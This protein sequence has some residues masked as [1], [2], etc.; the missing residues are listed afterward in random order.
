MD[1]SPGS[2]EGMAEGRA[3]LVLGV[4]GC[5]SVQVQVP[6]GVPPPQPVASREGLAA[7]Q[8]RSRAPHSQLSRWAWSD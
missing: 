5:G 1:L 2:E 7:Q 8:I 6:V 4:G 3:P